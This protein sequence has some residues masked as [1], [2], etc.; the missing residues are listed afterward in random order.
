MSY[1][2]G[3]GDHRAAFL[4]TGRPGGVVGHPVFSVCPEWPVILAAGRVVPT[5]S[6][7]TEQERAERARAV[8]F[9]HDLHVHRLVRPGDTLTTTATVVGVEHHRAGVLQTLRLDTI[10]ADRA[11]VATTWQ[12]SMFLGARLDG[13]EVMPDAPMLV[14]ADRGIDDASGP[15][16]APEGAT[17]RRKVDRGAAHV[18]TECARIWNPIHTD[19]VVARSA[20]LPDIILHGTATMAMAVSD[21]IDE[22]A[23]GDPTRVRRVSGR[24]AGMVLLPSDLVTRMRA[25]DGPDGETIV[26]V[27]V[28]TDQGG[29][30][31]V[32]FR[33][34]SVVLG[35]S[36]H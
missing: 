21:V 26:S 16:A 23:G 7:R 27:E 29:E 1:A 33:R 13:P 11:L 10:D 2:A 17:V 9:T 15:G 8:H 30:G 25:I 36:E 14:T 24:F 34:G 6:V 28:A 35:P 31:A 22:F 32:A 3:I 19:V 18:Y 20:G 4:D 12:S 5:G